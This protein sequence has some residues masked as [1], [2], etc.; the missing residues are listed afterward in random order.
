[1]WLLRS[2]LRIQF[3]H[4]IN[5]IHGYSQF[6][7]LE[8]LGNQQVGH[9]PKSGAKYGSRGKQD[10][11]KSR[12]RRSKTQ[13]KTNNRVEEDTTPTL[14]ELEE[15]ILA[16]LKNL[17]GQVF[18]LSPF[19]D[20]FDIWLTSLK[21]LLARFESS[22]LVTMD[23]Q[24]VTECDLAVSSVESELRE[25]KLK[26]T[27]G[28][29]CLIRLTDARNHLTQIDEK[30]CQKQKKLENSRANQTRREPEGSDSAGKDLELVDKKRTRFF[31][32]ILKK[33]K[34]VQE[35]AS[36]PRQNSIETQRNTSTRALLEERA[37]VREEYEK[38]KNRAV[39]N[40]R[41]CEKEAQ[42][43]GVLSQ[44]D[45][46][47]VVRKHACDTLS[48]SIGRLLEREQKMRIEPS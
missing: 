3:T 43:L 5:L 33:D 47:L 40:L 46:S 9:P 30:H 11:I 41:L 16:G 35:E 20:N 31:W 21:T 14:L 23:D 19:C 42:T 15:I 27:S 6:Y 10:K 13:L 24:Y 2:L 7:G 38:E 48:S 1:M 17:G 28:R 4:G 29:D 8:E 26:E 22:R 45:E 32:R 34:I 44:F 39:E 36:R 37:R 25:L 18:A 12:F